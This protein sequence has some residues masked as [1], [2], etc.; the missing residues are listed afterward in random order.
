M[1]FTTSCALVECLYRHIV[2]DGQDG[3]HD[4]SYFVS[5]NLLVMAVSGETRVLTIFVCSNDF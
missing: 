1:L 5:I 4:I 2:Y 3:V